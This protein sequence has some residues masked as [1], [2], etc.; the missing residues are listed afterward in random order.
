MSEKKYE[1]FIYFMQCYFCQT[2]YW[3]ELKNQV[4]EYRSRETASY[5]LKLKKELIMMRETH[6]W[7]VI[8][9]FISKNTDR[10]LGNEENVNHLIDTILGGLSN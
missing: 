7:E 5:C 3:S 4:K 10:R 6:T 9:R 2:Y 1:T 8:N